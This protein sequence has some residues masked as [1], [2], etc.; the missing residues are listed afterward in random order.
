MP[1]ATV[2]T[3]PLPAAEP[4]SVSANGLDLR[5]EPFPGVVALRIAPSSPGC[6]IAART[7]G[8]GL[9]GAVNRATA[10]GGRVALRLGPDE[11]LIDTGAEE[12]AEIANALRHALDGHHA[13][14]VDL[15]DGLSAFDIRGARSIDVLRKG[16][17]LDLDPAVFGTGHA[18][19]TSL[20]QATVVL[21][22]MDGPESWRLYVDS[23]FAAYMWAWLRDAGREFLGAGA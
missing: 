5:V 8:L 14:A 9:D 15:S 11:W 16:C 23:S 7:L 1:D 4:M 12:A 13:A 20:A 17:G 22:C 3:S 2:Y 6:R 18:S 21:R 19:R 10:A